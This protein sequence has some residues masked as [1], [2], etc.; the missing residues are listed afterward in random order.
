MGYAD[1][2]LNA[3]FASA[4]Q[5]VEALEANLV[6]IQGKNYPCVLGVATFQQIFEEQNP[7][8]SVQHLPCSI[9]K[10]YFSVQPVLGNLPAI[11]R[12]VA[13]RIVEV[14]QSAMTYDLTLESPAQ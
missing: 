7:F 8:R 2:I 13:W 11:A 3:D 4:I 9:L 1:P 12:G 5:D 6:T 14:K 10:S